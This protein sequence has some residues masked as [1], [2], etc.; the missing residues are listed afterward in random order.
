[1]LAQVHRAVESCAPK[2]VPVKDRFRHYGQVQPASTF[3]VMDGAY[4]RFDL[5]ES[6][7]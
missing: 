5:K 6:A 2:V 1:V 3:N 7:V 4:F